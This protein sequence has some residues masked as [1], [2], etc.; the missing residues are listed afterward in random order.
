MEGGRGGRERKKGIKMY[1][2]PVQFP[3][4]KVNIMATNIINSRG[5]I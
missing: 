3:T 5:N 1:Y 4:R 2:V